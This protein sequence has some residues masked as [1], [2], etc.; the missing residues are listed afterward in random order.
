MRGSILCW[1]HGGFVQLLCNLDN[2]GMNLGNG[3]I[4]CFKP[5]VFLKM[6]HC[7]GKI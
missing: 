7:F 2:W 1:S 3:N 4:Q 6:Y 5:L